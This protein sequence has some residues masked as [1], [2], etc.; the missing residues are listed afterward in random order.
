[1]LDAD[2]TIA[3]LTREPA[4]TALCVD[5]DGSLAPI[6]ERAEDA[7]ALPGALA[8]LARLAPKLGRIAVISGRPVG[9]LVEH[10][11]VPG[12]TYTGLYGMEHV[13]DGH[14]TV[15]PRV[16]PYLERIATLTNRLIGVFGS[17]L[18]EPKSGVSVTLHW[19]PAPDR[20]EEMCDVANEVAAE[21]GLAT[22]HTRMAIEI[23]PPVAVDKGD[24]ARAAIDGF[25]VAA[26][27][28]DDTGDVPAFRALRGAAAD[29]TLQAA[30]CIGVHSPEAPPELLEAVDILVDG[31]EG[32]VALLAR[33]ADEIVE[34][35]AGGAGG[36]KRS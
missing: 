19:R 4:R 9:Y 16:E 5:F 22:L 35:H 33:V 13:V 15:D 27:A 24:A 20:A 6:V 32:L 30:V 8:E 31:P 10:V 3:V 34:P 26:F 25:D 7:R 11:P 2:A 28:G 1:V 23:R 17:E 21:Y 14:R 36:R 18:V 12:V 29:G